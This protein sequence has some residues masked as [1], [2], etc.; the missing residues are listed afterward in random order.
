VPDLSKEVLLDIEKRLEKYLA[1]KTDYHSPAYI[2]SGGSAATYAVASPK[3]KRAIK[4]YDPKF[5][6]GH[7]SKAE[8]RR[9]ELQRSL[10]GH[11]CGQ[12]V[13]VY[14]VD[15]AEETAF[16]EMEFVEWPQLKEVIT[17]VPDQSVSTLIQELVT[18]A[19]Y[20]EK[21]GI[22]HRDIKPENIHV[23]KDFSKLKLLDLGVARGINPQEED[24][25]DG[26]DQGHT[27]PFIS[28]AQYSSPEY[29]FRLDEPSQA[30][31]KAL[32]LY[33][34]GAVLH[35]LI[36]KRP[37]FQDEVDKQNRWLVA[38]AVLD[39]TPSFPDADPS[40][41]ARQKALASR[42]L[43]K[44]GTIRLQ[45]AS[46]TDFD[47]EAPADGLSALHAK[48]TKSKGT[49]GA[50]QLAASRHRLDFERS[51]ATKRLCDS[52]KSELIAACSQQIRISMFPDEA[53]STYAF[54]Y[55]FSISEAATLRCR[56]SL[57]WNDDLQ[58]ETAT[59]V[60]EAS[61][62]TNSKPP[63]TTSKIPLAVFAIGKSEEVTALDV[64]NNVASML[65][66][67]ID[68]AAAADDQ[69]TLNGADVAANYRTKE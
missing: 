22:V 30:L 40:R 31:W 39:K 5:L 13:T 34:V 19:V 4:V 1:S 17:E 11:T 24:S 9:L 25:G 51:G 63:I 44:D 21:L 37:L 15:E 33:Q 64:S 7:A 29:L 28:T 56:I 6:A 58:S 2:A 54:A 62:V 45:I 52:I 12:L 36:N 46:W 67:A 42:C 14:A 50:Q 48:L 65:A 32:N 3:G 35:D 43:V 27:R 66:Y 18:A 10:I 55:E 16:V 20:L 60:A 57:L 41:L 23:S 61:I 26:T 49:A 68:L 47:F 59:V 53:A 38:R 69:D 8:K